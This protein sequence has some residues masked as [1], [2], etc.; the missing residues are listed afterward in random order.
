MS[1]SGVYNSDYDAVSTFFKLLKRSKRFSENRHLFVVYFKVIMLLRFAPNFPSK[2]FSTIR[3]IG[4]KSAKVPP[5][6]LR[7][8]S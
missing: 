6:R 7:D 5:P 3:T 2:I 8:I 4:N 1:T